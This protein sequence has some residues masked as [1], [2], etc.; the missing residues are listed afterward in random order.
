M[1]DLK[2]K[3]QID[4]NNVS[5]DFEIYQ[6]DEG[7]ITGFK[8]DNRIFRD[9]D[10]VK[11]AIEQFIELANSDFFKKQDEKV[12]KE[13]PNLE[14]PPTVPSET[15]QKVPENIPSKVPM[16]VCSTCKIEKPI[17][18][19]NKSKKDKLG[20]Q[21]TCR[22]CQGIYF[23]ERIKNIK[24]K[25]AKRTIPIEQIPMEV[26]AKT[27]RAPDNTA[28]YL[29]WLT[30]GNHRQFDI[31]DF[32]NAFPGIVTMESAQAIM[33]HQI[34]KNKLQQLSNTTFKVV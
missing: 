25:K 23:K 17:D 24:L 18:E 15:P 1:S 13:K 6:M 2:I 26:P 12:N 27:V 28:L 19:F 34:T 4:I 29:N 21:N 31:R 7:I 32:V 20:V 22:A 30:Q 5:H 14:V 33:S 9:M 3:T 10:K 16:K 8:F 11:D